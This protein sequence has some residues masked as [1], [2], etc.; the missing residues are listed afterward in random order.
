MDC[1]EGGEDA[2]G[3]VQR[4]SLVVDNDGFLVEDVADRDSSSL[5]G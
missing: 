5:R 3:R 4:H 1:G 2:I